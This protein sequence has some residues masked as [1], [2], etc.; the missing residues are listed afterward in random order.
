MSRL[1]PRTGGALLM[2]LRI[3]PLASSPPRSALEFD[4]PVTCW[5]AH[6]RRSGGRKR[7]ADRACEEKADRALSMEIEVH[8]ARSGFAFGSRGWGYIAEGMGSI[9]KGEID[10]FEHWLTRVRQD[11]L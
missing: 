1:A 9:T 5:P 8:H 7:A 3:L 6:P 2:A 11:G 10:A 4:A